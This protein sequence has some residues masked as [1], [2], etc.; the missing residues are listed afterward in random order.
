MTDLRT[1]AQ[2]DLRA[3]LARMK[4]D[5]QLAEYR[6]TVYNNLRL[7]MERIEQHPQ[8]EAGMAL[9]RLKAG[10]AEKTVIDG[11]KAQEDL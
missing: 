11:F 3:D 8:F 4:Y 2:N 6:E 9:L 5:A 10:F 1:E 7:A